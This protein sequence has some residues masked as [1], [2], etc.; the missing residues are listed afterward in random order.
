MNSLKSLGSFSKNNQWLLIFISIVFGIIATMLVHIYIKSKIISIS[1]GDFIP[2]LTVTKDMPDGAIVTE[3][4]I[5]IK[6]MPDLMTHSKMIHAQY[7]DF[8]VGQKAG[9]NLYEGQILLWNDMQVEEQ[10]TL[11][12]EL[13]VNERAVSVFVDE[14]TGLI[15]LLSPGDRVD[16]IGFFN[17][18]GDDFKSTESISKVL[19]QNITVLAVGTNTASSPDSYIARLASEQGSS[20]AETQVPKTVTLRLNVKDVPLF[21]FADKKGEILLSLRSYGDV[22]VEQIPEVGYENIKHIESKSFQ[23][24]VSEKGSYPLIYEGGEQKDNA[25]WPGDNFV[26]QGAAVPQEYKKKI[27]EIMD[28]VETDADKNF[29]TR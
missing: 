3:D 12:Q 6:E 29:V 10:K 25:Y 18:P 14:A 2:V 27:D 1:G 21:V 9:S 22:I 16:V 11:S 24:D 23:P 13:K 17:V 8:V 7:E 4:V 5:G 20:Y 19:L 26:G 28:G 15:G